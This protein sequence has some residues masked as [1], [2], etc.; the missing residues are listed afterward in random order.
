[1]GLISTLLLMVLF[2]LMPETNAELRYQ[3]SEILNGDWWRLYSGQLGHLGLNHLLL[4]MTGLF[5]FWLLFFRTAATSTWLLVIAISMTSIGLGLLWLN[6]EIEWYLGFSGIL[7]AL[8]FSALIFELKLGRYP[9]TF[10][11]L[12]L[13]LAKLV[14]EQFSGAPPGSSEL[15][16]GNVV[17]EAHLYGAISGA[18][19]GL[20]TPQR[21]LQPNHSQP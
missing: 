6:P 14:W 9:T 4:N 16:G 8:F 18:L 19:I 10:P 7:H 15:I 2:T 20:L 13:L 5:I 21:L 17:T 3:R 11:L 12:L 1:M